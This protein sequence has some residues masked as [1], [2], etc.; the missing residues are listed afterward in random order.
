[1]T[2]CGI[3]TCGTGIYGLSSELTSSKGAESK[4]ADSRPTS[5]GVGGQV[6]QQVLEVVAVVLKVP[7]VLIRLTGRREQVAQKV[8]EVVVVVP[9]VPELLSALVAGWPL[10]TLG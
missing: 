8:P 3:S 2:I 4:A 10:P 6:A 1:M 7:A 5:K 9:K